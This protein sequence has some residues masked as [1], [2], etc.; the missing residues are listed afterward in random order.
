MAICYKSFFL[1]RD[2]L[3]DFDEEGGGAVRDERVGK[4][5]N[6]IRIHAR[7]NAEMIFPPYGCR[8][9]SRVVATQGYWAAGRQN[10][11]QS[12]LSYLLLVKIV[13]VNYGIRVS[14]PVTPSPP[15]RERSGA[16]SASPKLSWL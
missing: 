8:T 11:T 6:S 5:L 3:G 16:Q 1:I 2:Q 9:N 7:S 4:G 10:C 12:R 13:P 15:A 14:G